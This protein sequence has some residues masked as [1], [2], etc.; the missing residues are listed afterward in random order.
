MSEAL[1]AWAASHAGTT[2]ASNQDTF[3]MRSE[4]GL[5]AVADG[6]GGHGGGEIASAAVAEALRGL[7]AG[8]SAGE[9]LGRV[10]LALQDTNAALRAEAEA[11]GP[12]AM[13]A[14]T[15]VALLV[16]DG[17][18]ACLWAGD[19]RCYL[20]RNGALSCVTRDHSLVQELVD[21]GEITEAAAERHPQANVVT[22]AIG[23]DDT[24]ALDKVTG[25]VL[26]GDAFVLLSDGV[27]KALDAAVLAET[28]V[29][30]D[31]QALADALIA[32]AMTRGSTDNVTA[33][34]VRCGGDDRGGF[35]EGTIRHA[36]IAGGQGGGR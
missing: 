27:T 23:A 22:R 17:H 35:A 34:V 4:I 29:A 10:R 14:S 28:L 30:A 15:V 1:R 32:L 16:R 7:P 8:L 13:L 5:W 12:R 9:L 20:W 11:R 21:R 36:S 18:F 2:R 6:A 26:A 3:L 33:L 19:S 25:Q 24:L 31:G